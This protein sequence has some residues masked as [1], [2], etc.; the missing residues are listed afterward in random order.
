MATVNNV[1]SINVL[2]I[3]HE[4]GNMGGGSYSMFNMINSVRDHVN[5]FILTKAEGGVYIHAKKC[6]YPTIVQKFNLNLA[7]KNRFKRWIYHF[8]RLVLD[9]YINNLCIK[10][11]AKE[12]SGCK[13]DIVHTNSALISFGGKLARRMDAKHVWHLREFMNLDFKLTPVEGFYKLKKEIQHSDAIIAITNAVFEHWGCQNMQNAYVLYNAVRSKED[14][15]FI[16]E[17]EKYVLFCAGFVCDEKGADV[18]A[19]IFFMS[20]IAQL[21]YKLVYAGNCSQVYR[22]KLEKISAK[23]NCLDAYKFVGYQKDIKELMCKASAFLMC[24][25]NEAMG[26][27]TVEAMFYGCPILGNNSGGTKEIIEDR[28]NGLLYNN[29]YDASQLL[30]E[31]VNSKELS[32]QLVN[33][34]HA[35]AEAYFSEEIYKSKILNIYNSI[36]GTI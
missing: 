30:W 15:C 25:P 13:I 5:P 28:Y 34:A 2:F 17:K 33:N 16:T 20:N 9:N 14:I 26:R 31:I 24:S 12:F 10:R 1:P 21:G 23:Y 7:N 32:K 18:A 19:E 11:V 22:Q 35:K 29:L 27:V 8:P 3:C 6:G 36:L 4:E